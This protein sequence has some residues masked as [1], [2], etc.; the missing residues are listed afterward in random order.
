MKTQP[1]LQDPDG[2]YA[3]WVQAHEGLDPDQSADLQARLVLLLAN[4]IGDA[5]VLR[6]CLA[7]ARAAAPQLEPSAGGRP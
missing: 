4:Q 5:A 6:Q 7:A 1:H 3:D 2:F